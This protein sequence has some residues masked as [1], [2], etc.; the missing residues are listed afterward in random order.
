[1]K[2]GSVDTLGSCIFWSKRAVPASCKRAF[3]RIDT[4]N[5]SFSIEAQIDSAMSNNFT[6][7]LIWFYLNVKLKKNWQCGFIRFRQVK[8]KHKALNRPLVNFLITKTNKLKP[9]SYS[10]G[11]SL[12]EKRWKRHESFLFITYL[13]H[14]LFIRISSYE[15]ALMGLDKKLW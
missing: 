10:A 9:L 12:R 6:S 15:Q 4:H 3:D 1:M 2:I 8:L 11:S 7:Q 13:Y 5:K 14:D